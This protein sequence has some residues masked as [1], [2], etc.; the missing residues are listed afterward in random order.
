MS[1]KHNSTL[2]CVEN[3][4]GAK[5]IVITGSTN[6]LFW[7]ENKRLVSPF[8]PCNPTVRKRSVKIHFG[9]TSG[10]LGST[11]R[12]YFVSVDVYM[13]LQQQYIGISQIWEK[14]LISHNI[15]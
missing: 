12:V 11:S 15:D 14:V 8:S 5:V 3:C 10:C 2:F 4:S 6:E 13:P 1:R 7:D 9:A